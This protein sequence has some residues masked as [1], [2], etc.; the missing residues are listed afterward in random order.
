M[1]F[2]VDPV[3]GV[4]DATIGSSDGGPGGSLSTI[5]VGDMWI[6]SKTGSSS[7]SARHCVNRTQSWSGCDDDAADAATAVR[8]GTLHRAVISGDELAKMRAM[9]CEGSAC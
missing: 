7:F 9:A 1:G 5:P 2:V 4:D 3:D 6:R 8:K